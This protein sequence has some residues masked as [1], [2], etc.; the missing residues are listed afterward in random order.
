[1]KTHNDL[2][3]DFIE[4]IVLKWFKAEMMVFYPPS[5][6]TLLRPSYVETS[7]GQ[8]R[9]RKGAATRVSPWMN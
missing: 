1:M 7:E 8:A 6:K 3:F 4:G 5:Q 2:F 9:L